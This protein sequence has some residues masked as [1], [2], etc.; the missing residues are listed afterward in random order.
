MQFKDL[1]VSVQNIAAQLLADKMLHHYGTTEQSE[2]A[3]MLAQN[4]KD[5]FTELYS[6]KNLCQEPGNVDLDKYL[7]LLMRLLCEIEQLDDHE[8][9][10]SAFRASLDFIKSELN[11]SHQEPS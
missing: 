9:K 2:P 8:R 3:K 5:A 1:P 6:S 10:V 7:K 11:K 4:I